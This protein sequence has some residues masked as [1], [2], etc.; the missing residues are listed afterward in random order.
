MKVVLIG[1]G[2][3]GHITPLLAVARELKTLKSG[4]EIVGVCETGSA[5]VDLYKNCADIDEVHQVPAGKYRRYGGRSLLRR[6]TDVETLV[7]NGR[8]VFRTV[9]GYRQARRLLKKLKP[10]IMLVKGGFVG[11]PLG[12]AAARLKLPFITHDSDSVPGLANRII[13]RWAGLHATGMPADLYDYPKDKTVYTGVPVSAEF[14]LVDDK[15]RASYRQQLGLEAWHPVITVVGGS[16]GGGQLNEDIVAISA[17]L[18]KN[19]PKLAIVHVAGKAH[20][21]TVMQDYRRN[22]EA[23]DLTRL[24]VSGFV[25]DIATRQGAADVVVSRAG[26][27]QTAELAVQGLPVIFVPGRLA[28]SHQ[29]KNAQFFAGKGAALVAPFGDKKAL[30]ARIKSLLDDAGMRS[31]ISRQF[32][33]FAKPNAA[34]ELA[35]TLL[36]FNEYR[37]K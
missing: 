14:E 22:L 3:G 10:D 7:L 8:D 27:S 15:Q 36:D 18:M 24:Q 9:R 20:A 32:N 5:F 6:A 23:Q 26:A 37:D 35:R 34:G 16:Q 12:L 30:K 19:Y 1:G 17:D 11:V 4:I 29:D 21:E 33:Q 13:S 25:T 28:G 31:D 2:S